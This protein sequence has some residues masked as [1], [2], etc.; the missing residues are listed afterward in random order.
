LSNKKLIIFL[1]LSLIALT[2][3]V[4]VF[5][6]VIVDNK[7]IEDM[8]GE[9]SYLGS[10]DIENVLDIIL[11]EPIYMQINSYYT[12]E[13]TAFDD[14]IFILGHENNYTLRKIIEMKFNDQFT[15]IIDL[16]EYYLPFLN[17]SLNCMGLGYDGT[18]FFTLQTANLPIKQYFCTF[19]DSHGLISNR[20]LES[21]ASSYPDVNGLIR[22]NFDVWDN[23]IYA[24]EGGEYN[25]Y[26]VEKNITSYDLNTLS[27]VDS[28]NIKDVPKPPIHLHRL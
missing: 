20:T 23:K 24:T 19:N 3:S 11:D 2:V 8:Y 18:N 27:I 5:S 13:I 4:S 1:S 7:K 17:S 22:T 9:L 21:P 16:K 25:G 10:K 12:K 14:R 15:S 6:Y 28:F 26:W